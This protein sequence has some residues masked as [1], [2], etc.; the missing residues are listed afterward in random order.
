MTVFALLFGVFVYYRGKQLGV[1]DRSQMDLHRYFGAINTLLL[2]TSSLA[3]VTGVRAQGPLCRA[4]LHGAPRRAAVLT[5]DRRGLLPDRPHH[6][7]HH[8]PRRR[9]QLSPGGN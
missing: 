2:L 9:R 6:P 3:V 8:V 7:D 4:L 5:G 1:F